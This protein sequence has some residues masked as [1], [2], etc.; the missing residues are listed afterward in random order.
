[1]TRACR[2]EGSS[3]WCHLSC[4]IPLQVKKVGAETYIMEVPCKATSLN[5]G[6]SFILDAGETIYVWNGDEASP[7]ERSAANRE[8]E[9]MERSRAGK[10]Q[11]SLEID[12]AFWAAL[13]G[14]VEDVIAAADAPAALPPP[15]SVGEGVLFR[16][17]DASSEYAR[18]VVLNLAGA[19]QLLRVGGWPGRMVLI[20]VNLLMTFASSAHRLR[21]TEEARGELDKSQLDSND[22]FICDTGNELL[23]WIGNKASPIESAR[24]MSTA[25]KYLDQ[26]GK[27]FVTTPISVLKERNAE[28]NTT[29]KQIFMN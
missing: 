15:A 5:H 24:S 26:K 6:D 1:M 28:Q 27:S 20:S 22:V 2:C 7:F 29:F 17:S 25:S 8:A 10:G 13:G 12:D 9:R 3:A 16:L 14:T 11:A 4:S 23:V 19:G 21:V 18:A